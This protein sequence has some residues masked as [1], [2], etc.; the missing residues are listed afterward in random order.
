MKIVRIRS[1]GQTGVDRAALD[2]ARELGLPI[3]GWCP[4]N[5]RAE[6]HEDP[7]DDWLLKQYPELRETNYAGFSQRTVLN[8]WDADATI[9][10]SPGDGKVSPGTQLTIDE[11]KKLK[12]PYFLLRDENVTE[13]LKWLNKNFKGDIEVNFAGPRA[14]SSPGVYDIAK[15]IIKKII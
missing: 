1:G 9:I 2:A 3:A 6:D 13:V 15:E 7:A 14:S 12:K 5:G 11:A 10:I 4:K 8:I